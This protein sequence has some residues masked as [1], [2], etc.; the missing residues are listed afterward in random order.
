[1]D[2]ILEWCTVVQGGNATSSGAGRVAS[3][4]DEARYKAV[5]NCVVIVAIETVLKEVSRCEGSLLCE[6][7]EGEV[8]G[9]GVEDDLGRGLRFEIIEVRH[10]GVGVRTPGRS[11]AIRNC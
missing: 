1:M 7:L 2:F 9:G 5:E 4:D 3:L 11:A 8:A 10:L 6:E